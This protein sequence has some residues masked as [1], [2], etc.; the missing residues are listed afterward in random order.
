[1]SFRHKRQ[2][3]RLARA[4]VSIDLS[5]SPPWWPSLP[6]CAPMVAPPGVV[7]WARVIVLLPFSVG[8]LLHAQRVRCLSY[9]PAVL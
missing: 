7:P 2:L 5:S 4:V 3:H 6:Y 9:R 1:M 8:E